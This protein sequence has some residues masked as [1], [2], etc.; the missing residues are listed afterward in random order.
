[1]KAIA[2][3]GIVLLVFGLVTLVSGGFPV[4]S[5]T[6]DSIDIGPLQATIKKEKHF[7][8]PAV[9]SIA[10]IGAGITLLVLGRK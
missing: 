3:V 10:A 7:P 4:S 8:V 5:N 9:F 6:V 1:M 2:I